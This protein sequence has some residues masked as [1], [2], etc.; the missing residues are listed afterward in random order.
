MKLIHWEPGGK[1][2]LYHW[3]PACEKLHVIPP[4]GWTRSGPDDSPTYSPSFL[5][6][7]V[8]KSGENCHYFIKNGML[9]YCPDS[10]HKRNDTVPMPEIPEDVVK[11]LTDA[12]FERKT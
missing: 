10:W 7:H 8:K 4:K 5:Q 3:C 2:T 9:E 12:I 11:N 6:Y 1:D